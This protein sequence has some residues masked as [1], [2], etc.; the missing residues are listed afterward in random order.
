MSSQ[1]PAL[2]KLEP[3]TLT[4]EQTETE[5][6]LQK[7]LEDIR[8]EAETAGS[9]PLSAPLPIQ[10]GELGTIVV[11]S[12]GIR[13]EGALAASQPIPM[14]MFRPDAGPG[15]RLTGAPVVRGTTVRVATILFD[16]GSSKL[17]GLDKR[18]LSS[19]NIL[20]RD[21]GGTIL[22][23]G[24][25]SE[26]TRNLSP[27]RHKMANFHI[28]VARADK[29]FSELVRLGVSRDKIVITAVS[30]A[31][32]IFYEFMPSGEAGNRRAEVYLVN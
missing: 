14:P 6:R 22:I 29:V 1:P 32:P 13:I 7:Q 16:N 30:D 3:P 26:R 9:V 8:T 27:I 28:S 24:H 20:Q 11:S 4:V 19:V 5:T 15:S 31:E 17:K 10:P 2:P 21:N 12:E 18:I 23:V 25:A